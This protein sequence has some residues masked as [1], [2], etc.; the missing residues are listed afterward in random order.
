[1]AAVAE[2]G[3]GNAAN[4]IFDTKTVPEGVIIPPVDIRGLLLS[5]LC[6]WLKLLFRNCGKDSVLCRSK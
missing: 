3:G 5:I 4:G 1:M 2:G 6:R